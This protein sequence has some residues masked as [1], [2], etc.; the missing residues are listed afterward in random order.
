MNETQELMMKLIR[1]DALEQTAANA[2]QVL[3]LYRALAEFVSNLGKIDDDLA[4]DIRMVEQWLFAAM[5]A[6]TGD[7][8]LTDEECLRMAL[9]GL[10]RLEEASN[11]VHLPKGGAN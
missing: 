3:A 2:V 7:S 4:G 6:G 10:E 5:R 11:I 8:S 1:E 9:A